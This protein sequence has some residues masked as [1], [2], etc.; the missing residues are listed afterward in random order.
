M[1]DF[2]RIL[3]MDPSIIKAKIRTSSTQ[4]EKRFLWFAMAIRSALIVAFAILFI[5]FFSA[6]FGSE[7]TPMAVAL[8]CIMLG[9]RFVNFEYCIKD[10]M[11]TLAVSLLLL[12]IAPTLVTVVPKILIPVIHFAAFG[13]ILYMTCQR[14]ELG[15]GG[16]YN[17]AYVYLVGNPVSGQLLIQRG[18]LTAVGYFICGLILLAKHRHMHRDI[19]FH[20]VIKG[21]SLRNPVH[22][23]QLRMAIGVS[24]VLTAGSLLHVE[25]FM[26]MGFACASLLCTYPYSGNISERSWHRI[27]GAVMGSFAFF[28]IF[29]LTPS[30]WHFL[31][32]PLGGLCLGFCTDYRWKTAMNCFG[33]LMLGAGIYGIQ[34]AVVLRIWDTILGVIFALLFS[35]LFHKIVGLKMIPDQA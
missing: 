30:S 20:H 2:Y 16:L 23:W 9:I 24:L 15:N 25:R 7:N 22:L 28:L 35:V 34:G 27:L 31:L 4:K 5:G 1:M 8:F 11:I 32:G 13:G 6:V 3:Q 17:F 29:Q 19:R 12:L 18:L 33:A 14:P 26:W 10:S 21:F